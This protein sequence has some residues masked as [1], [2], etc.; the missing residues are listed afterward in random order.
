MA[1]AQQTGQQ[2]IAATHG[3]A[4]RQPL[5]VGIVGDQTLVP[6]EFLPRD[7]PLVVIGEQ[8]LPVAL[9]PAIASDDPL[10]PF[11]HAH[12]A[13]GSAEGISARVNRVG[14]QMQD[15]VVD[16]QFPYDRRTCWPLL[17]SRKANLFLAQP[18]M[19]LPHAAALAELAEYQG[20]GLADP[21][22]RIDLDRVVPRLAVADRH[23]EEQLATPRLLAQGLERALAEQRQ[24][25]LAHRAFRDGDIL[26][27]NSLLMF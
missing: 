20:D 24:L 16:R 14:Q 10:A 9:R 21:Q 5:A 7:V 4:R 8:H 19:H 15:R 26:P 2:R 13:A 27:K 18:Q 1:A 12:P 3:A 17:D 22:I 6:L 23:G 11:P 25:H